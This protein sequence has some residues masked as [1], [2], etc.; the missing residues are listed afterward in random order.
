[1]QSPLSFVV[2]IVSVM[3]VRGLPVPVAELASGNAKLET[4]PSAQPAVQPPTEQYPW[5]YPPQFERYLPLDAKQELVKIYLDT[6]LTP[7]ERSSRVNSV[8]D[9][10]P[11]EIVVRLPLP[12]G[13]E[14]LPADVFNRILYVRSAP[15]FKWEERQELI[16]DIVESLP[17][18]QRRAMATRLEGPPPGFEQFLP[19]TIYKK[20]LFVHYDRH[21]SKVQKAELIT[22]IMRG[23]PEAI[24][25]KLPLPAGMGE[26][27]EELQ[28]RLRSLVYDYSVEQKVRAKRVREFVARIPQEIRPPL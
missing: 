10:L 1:M 3:L 7:E 17:E 27:P 12:N 8:F 9:S 22:R 25:E 19:P 16:R 6:T 28:R 5:P 14:R 18:E 2:M 23:V 24:I 21:L 13:F 4:V 11:M 15:G 26:L 20:L